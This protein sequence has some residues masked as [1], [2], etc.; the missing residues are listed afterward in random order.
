MDEVPQRRPRTRVNYGKLIVLVVVAALVALL[1]VQ[2][3]RSVTFSFVTLEFSAPL[4][5]MLGIVL[6]I[7]VLAGWLLVASRRRRR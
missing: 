7:G 4:W 5:L 1:I 2:N 3:T 6:A